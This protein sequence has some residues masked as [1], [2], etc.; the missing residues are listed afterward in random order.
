MNQ[1][2]KTAIALAVA[3]LAFMPVGVAMA[4]TAPLPAAKADETAVVV[5]SG[6]RAAL[7][8]AQKI[9]QNADE[10]VDSVVADDIG[11]LPDRSVTEVLQRMPGVTIDRVLGRADPLQGVGEDNR[12][13]AEGAGVSIRGMSY[14]RSEL[15]GRDSF[16]ANGGRALSFEDVPPELMAG[17]DIYKNPSA[18]QTEGAIG[19]LVNL[20]TAMPFDFKGAKGAL[21]VEASRASLR[22]KSEPAFSALLSNR[23]DTPLGQFGALID[24]AH[25]KIATRS[26]GLNIGHYF[27]R[28]N[29]LQGDTSGTEYWIPGAGLSWNTSDFER[30]RDGVYGALQWKKGDFSSGLTYF[31]SKYKLATSER[32]SY[33]FANPSEVTVDAGAT[34]SPNG[35]LLTG[36]LRDATA[37]GIGYGTNAR[38]VGRQS[39]TGDLAWNV[40]WKASSRLTLRADLQ[41]VRSTTD[42]YDN[43]VAL[44]GLMPKQ[45]V[46]LTG[47]IPKVSFD[48]A[49]QAFM[50]NPANLFWDSTQQHRDVAVATQNALRLD[51]RY[52]FESPVLQDLR[53][54]VRATERKALTQS[55]TPNNQWSAV[56][57]SWAVDTSPNHDSWQ[58]LTAF[59]LL[60]DPR[61]AGNTS[62]QN[63]NGFFGGKVQAPAALIMPNMDLTT[64]GAPPPSFTTI[65][66]FAKTVCKTPCPDWILWSPAPFGDPIATNDQAEKTTSAFGQLRFGFNELRYPV[67]GN[68]GLRV[69]R[70][71]ETATGYT[72]FTPPT[73][74]AGIGGVPVIAAQTDKK[75]F[76]HAYTNVLPS[77]NLKMKVGDELQFRFAASQGISRPDFYRMQAYTTLAQNVH[78][79]TDQTTHQEVLDSIDYTGT[80]NGNTNLTPVKS[81]NLDLTAEYYFGRSSSF[82]GSFFTKR[83]KDIVVDRT[84]IYPVKDVAGVSH[85]FLVSGPVNAAKG[86]VTGI[87]LAYQQ[88]FDKLPGLLSG[89]G[90]SGNYTYIDS[91]LDLGLP[92]GR[93]WCTPSSTA[94]VL[95]TSLGGCDTNGHYFG[96]LPLTGLSRNSYNLS[97]LY[98]KG[99]VSARMA[100][101]WRSKALQAVH[102]WGTYGTDGIDRNPNGADQGKGNATTV[103]YALPAWSGEY[104][105]L[106]MGV[107]YK[108]LDNL[109]VAFDVTNLTNAVSKNYSQ[110]SIGMMLNSVYY[111]GRRFSLQG[112]YS[113]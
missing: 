80:A 13:A 109:T 91:R 111:T 88:Y 83:L 9:K 77:L 60:S 17:V 70:T 45:T 12:F 20:R 61:F 52:I 82:T 46:D 57:P 71:Q 31:K 72:L 64:G 58:P 75:T 35:T 49:D 100:Y 78:T 41:R 7:Q 48:A 29:A 89:F 73:V 39:E 59:A 79:H 25:S 21:T 47:G 28:T 18:E 3:Q 95:V 10:I 30:T 19:G 87:E 102:T 32:Q 4:Q 68:V 22:G 33:T 51:A 108:A 107:Q 66:N 63:F 55:N 85:D 94:A 34:F 44:S 110:Q 23:W 42:G 99:P 105:Q 74:A 81:N 6:Q 93:T 56:T 37:G 62:V 101:T 15:N 40:Q 76:E 84:V 16:S 92:A 27:S 50:V 38:S 90:L 98:D 53:F 106:D 86:R 43:L 96:D 113:F 24:V 1:F 69:V 67:D 14:V 103:N 11:K 65:H 2:N 36:V 54:G 104:G 26:N 112:R 5:V 8:S 97:L